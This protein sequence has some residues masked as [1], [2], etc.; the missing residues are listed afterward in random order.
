MNKKVFYKRDAHYDLK[1]KKN[2]KQDLITYV[3]KLTNADHIP[4]ESHGKVITQ[5]EDNG[6][7]MNIDGKVYDYSEFLALHILMTEI[8]NNDKTICEKNSYF[9]K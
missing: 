8:I 2:K 5:I 1:I 9:V 6:D 4:H 7:G 3:L